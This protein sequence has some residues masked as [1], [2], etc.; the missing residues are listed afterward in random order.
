M[1]PL[2]LCLAAASA[3]ALAAGLAGCAA[4]P[5]PSAAHLP[6]VHTA[7]VTPVAAPALPAPVVEAPAPPATA[8][9]P[10]PAQELATHIS[11]EPDSYTVDDE[12]RAALQA[13]V[14]RLQADPQ[15]RLVVRAY[16]DR[17]GSAAYRRALADKRAQTLRKLLLQMGANAAQV[18]AMG[19]LPPRGA[20]AAMQRAD[21]AA[22]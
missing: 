3:L 20:K 14:Q 1:T 11:F 9:A 8:P 12:A 7:P 22:R 2:R 4:T 15:R 17:N 13:H 19:V 6:P 18:R 5:G 16:P 10:A 21:L